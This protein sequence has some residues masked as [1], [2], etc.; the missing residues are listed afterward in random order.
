LN[1]KHKDES[2]NDKL[3]YLSVSELGCFMKDVL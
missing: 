2:N 1:I 3:L